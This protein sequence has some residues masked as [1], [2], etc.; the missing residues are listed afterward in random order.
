MKISIIIPAFNEEKLLGTTLRSIDAALVSFRTIGC[1]TETIVCDNNSTD[2]TAEIARAAGAKVVFEPINQIARA[3]NCG[4]AAAIGD[5]LIFV[6]GDSCPSAELFSDVA[7]VIQSGKAIAG[8]STVTLET[9]NFTVRFF[10]G[11]WNATSRILHWVA[12]SFIFCEAKVFRDIGGFSTEFFTGEELDLS[13][14]LKRYARKQNKKI[15]I[16]SKHPLLTSARKMHLYRRGEL[17]RFLLKA[18][19][20]PNATMK[21]REASSPWYDGRR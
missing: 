18:F 17:G 14:R 20:R 9:T 11:F 8:G 15:V 16:L 1:E 21:S 7:K 19:F 13:R 10:A 5:W 2:A 4:A 6:D 3:R 12:G